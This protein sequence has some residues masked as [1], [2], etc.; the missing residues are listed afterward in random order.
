MSDILHEVVE[1]IESLAQA[2]VASV[3]HFVSLTGW[4]C[5]VETAFVIDFEQVGDFVE[6]VVYHLLVEL[7]VLFKMNE[8]TE[9]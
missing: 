5:F 1:S 7:L 6:L 2:W 9:D 4:I 3:F 8:S